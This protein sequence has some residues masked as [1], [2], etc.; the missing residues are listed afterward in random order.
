MLPPLQALLL[1]YEVLSARRAQAMPDKHAGSS[2]AIAVSQSRTVAA[3]GRWQSRGWNGGEPQRQYFP[4]ASGLVGDAQERALQLLLQAPQLASLGVPDVQ[5]VSERRSPGGVHVRFQQHA[6]G[7][8]LWGAEAVVSFDRNSKPLVVASELEADVPAQSQQASILAVA[9]A[10]DKAR[11]AVGF[12]S[13]QLGEPQGQLFWRRFSANPWQLAWCIQLACSQPSGDWQVWLD[14]HSGRVLEVHDRTVHAS[15]RSRAPQRSDAPGS[16]RWFASTSETTAAARIFLPDPVIASGNTDL[17]DEDDAAS[18]VPFSVYATVTLRGLDAPKAGVLALRG[19]YVQVVDWENPNTEPVTSMDA[20][21]EFDRSQSGFEDVMVY[22]H[23]DAMQRWY[24]SLGFA[25]ANN[26]SQPADA[27]GF[28]G[29]DN[30]KYIPSLGWLSFGEGGVDD[31]E[32]AAVIIHEYGHATQY[33][34]IPTW[35]IGG[36][37]AAMGEGFGDYLANSY[38]YAAQ[39]QRVMDWNGVFQWDGHNEFW[40]GR[41][42]IKPSLHYPQDADGSAHASGT[43]WCS[44]LTDALYLLADRAVMDGLVLNHHYM[45]TGNATMEDAANAIL[46]SDVALYDGAHLAALTDVFVRWGMIDAASVQPVLLLHDPPQMRTAAASLPALRAQFVAMDAASEPQ[47]AWMHTV[48]EQGTQSSWPMQ[49][50]GGGL[51]QCDLPGAAGADVYWRYWFEC[52]DAQDRQVV[53]PQGGEA[54]AYEYVMGMVAEDFEAAGGWQAGRLEDDAT[55]G[56]WVRTVPTGTAWQPSLD[57]SSAGSI[58]WVTGNAEPGAPA[59]DADVDDGTTTLRSPIWEVQGA[60]TLTLSYWRWFSTNAA[61]SQEDL[62]CVRASADGGASWVILEQTSA[63]DPGWHQRRFDLA[64]LLPAA[65]TIQLQ[66]EVTD[67][68][69]GSLVEAAL[70]DVVLRIKRTTDSAAVPSAPGALAVYPNPFNPTTTVSLAIP[71]A[72]PVRIDIY[73]TKGRL[74]RRLLDTHL[75]EGPH[76]VVWDGRDT[77]GR[78]LASGVYLLQLRS[79]LHEQTRKVTLLR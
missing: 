43:L 9:S 35:G 74:V 55:R 20:T 49:A 51:W 72:G 78:Q 71:A 47:Q 12:R 42:V 66:F 8:P 75:A 1:S 40:A 44:A 29:E 41:P 30:S 58:C 67:G 62:W 4:E 54:H 13:G 19:T 5:V 37:A 59:S 28:W 69:S 46:L 70:D 2:S 14:A 7:I 23:I 73:D 65:T 26:R 77:A 56:H 38:A 45:L 11:Q 24:Q 76:R 18:A 50:L 15:R 52:I 10:I 64:A 3:L 6:A 79:R 61:A 16:E 31:A 39:P 48:D 36:H 27:H 22:Y 68:G 63:G 53:L 17:R 57:H 34:I 33:D 25:D 21:F 32:D 60:A